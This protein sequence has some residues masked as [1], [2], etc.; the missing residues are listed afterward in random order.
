MW[1]A[2]RSRMGAAPAAAAA[3]A[4]LTIATWGAGLPNRPP[5]AAGTA[6]AATPRACASASPAGAGPAAA[7]LSARVGL[8]GLT[9]PAAPAPPT[10]PPSAAI[11]AI[12][13]EPVVSASA[14][15]ASLGPPASTRTAPATPTRA[16]LVPATATANPSPPSSPSTRS[17]TATRLTLPG[18]PR[19][20]MLRAG[21]SACATRGWGWGRGPL[22]I[23]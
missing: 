7:L 11:W 1:A 4:T 21:T 23:L 5:S 15:R 20:G 3:P 9:R 13:T 14:A 8:P 2:C 12:A 18:S 17:H 22:A 6:S 10:P 19:P 16:R